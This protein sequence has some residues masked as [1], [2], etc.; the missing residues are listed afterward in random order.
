MEING[1][2]LARLITKA[3]DDKKALDINILDLRGISILADYFV[4]CSGK[5]EIQ[6]KA[7]ARAITGEVEEELDIE[8]K[9]KEG[10]DQAKWVLLDYADVIVHI[11]QQ[12]E[13]EFYELER[14]W[15]DAKEVTWES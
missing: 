3:A 14:L 10:M 5:T 13:R 15:G 6:V 1:E 7:I 11:F 9:R 12:E 2:E 8:L 4:I